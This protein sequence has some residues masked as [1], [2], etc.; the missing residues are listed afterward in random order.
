MS[1]AAPEA[2]TSPSDCRYVSSRYFVSLCQGAGLLPPQQDL[3]PAEIYVD[4]K[5]K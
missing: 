2:A 4:I 1:A 5:D 3:I